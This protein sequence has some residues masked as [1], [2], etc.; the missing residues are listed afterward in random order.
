MND[1]QLETLDQIRQFL[2]GTEAIS[3]QI[4]SKDAR[5]RWI[6]HAFSTC[7]DARPEQQATTCPR[8]YIS[9][10]THWLFCIFAPIVRVYGTA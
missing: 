10:G 9:A 1:T 6:Q 7:Y 8:G 2:E 3:F 4:E 5:Y